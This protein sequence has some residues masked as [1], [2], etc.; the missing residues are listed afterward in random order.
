MMVLLVRRLDAVEFAVRGASQLLRFRGMRPELPVVWVR[1]ELT[2]G[3]PGVREWVGVE[4]IWAL[5]EV[6]DGF[7]I[8]E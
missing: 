5:C 7:R 1:E 6:E 8:G 2:D 4:G 3:L